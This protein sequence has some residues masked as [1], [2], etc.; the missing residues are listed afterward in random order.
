MESLKRIGTLSML[1]VGWAM[2]LTVAAFTSLNSL[3]PAKWETN[4]ALFRPR[5][6]MWTCSFSGSDLQCLRGSV[7]DVVFGIWPSREK[8]KWKR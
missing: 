7:V 6:L 3:P 8:E 5:F 1:N 2:Q 4:H